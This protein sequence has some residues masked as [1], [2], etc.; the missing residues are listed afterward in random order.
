MAHSQLSHFD[1]AGLTPEERF[2]E[3]VAILAS[4]LVLMQT[5]DRRRKVATLENLPESTAERL[6]VSPCT[7]LSVTNG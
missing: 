7:V 1:L 4:G 5:R 2:S 6:D 3:I